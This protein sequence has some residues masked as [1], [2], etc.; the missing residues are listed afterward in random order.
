MSIHLC[1]L[2][3]WSLADVFVA[4]DVLPVYREVLAPSLCGTI[5]TGLFTSTQ[6]R[7]ISRLCSSD[8]VRVYAA[9]RLQFT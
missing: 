3:W 2:I 7:L 1:C 4:S 5:R 6:P 8:R 9:A